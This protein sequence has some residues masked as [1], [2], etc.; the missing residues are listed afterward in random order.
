MPY[1]YQRLLDISYLLFIITLLVITTFY[2]KEEIY[3]GQQF[4]FRLEKSYLVMMVFLLAESQDRAGQRQFEVGDTLEVC[5]E[6]RW[7]LC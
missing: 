4:W 3:F 5:L 1:I 2:F 7:C 6:S